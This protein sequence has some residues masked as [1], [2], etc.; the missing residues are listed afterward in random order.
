MQLAHQRPVD[1]AVRE[2]EAG[3]VTVH[4][5]PFHLGSPSV[6]LSLQ[7]PGT[8]VQFDRLR[9]RTLDLGFVYRAPEPE[10]DLSSAVVLDEPLMLAQFS[11]VPPPGLLPFQLVKVEGF[12]FCPPEPPIQNGLTRLTSGS[13]TTQPHVPSVARSF[14][15]I[16]PEWYCALRLVAVESMSSCTKSFSAKDWIVAS[17]QPGP[18]ARQLS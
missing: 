13:A 12:N 3:E 11:S 1:F 5:Q 9:Q 17:A 14:A 4:R 10:S 15:P 18:S 2:L 6:T 16:H 7:G 8:S